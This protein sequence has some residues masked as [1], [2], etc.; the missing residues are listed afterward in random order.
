MKIETKLG[1]ST[2]V[3]ILA[4]FVSVFVAQLRVQQ[5]DALSATVTGERLPV[6]SLI[7]D[8]RLAPLMSVRALESYMLF[9]LDPDSSARFRKE[10]R[11]RLLAGENSYTKLLTF[12]P[13][14]SPE[15]LGRIRDFQAGVGQLRELEEEVERQ[16]ELHTPEGTSQAYDLIQKRI[17]PLDSSLFASL[18]GF[19]KTQEADRDHE[20]ELLGHAN[21]SVLV[22]LWFDSSVGALI[23]GIV[24]FLLG[25]RITRAIRLVVQRADAIAGGDLTGAPLAI[26]SKDQIGMLAISMQQMQESLAG[27][28]G[29]VVETAGELSASAVSMRSASDQVHHR[30]DQQTQQTQQTATAMQEMSASIA[31]VSRHTQSA[32]ESAR[33]AAQTAREGGAIVRQML[34]GMASIASAVSETSSTVGLL[35]ADS[36]RISQIVTVIDEIARKTN[37]LALNAAI[38]AARAGEQGRGFAVVAGEVRH[39]AESTAKAT[40]EIAAMIQGVQNRTE[41]AIGSMR[42]GNTTVEQGVATTNLAGESL[43]RIIGMAERV[44]RMITQIAIAASQQA[45]AADQSS[46]A[47]DSIHSLSNEN[48]GELAT[49]TSGIERLRRTAA[50]LESHVERFR[51]AGPSAGAGPR[52]SSPLPLTPLPIAALPLT[53]LPL[54]P[55]AASALHPA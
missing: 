3:L 22:A 44:E 31:E 5:A 29:T 12:G 28:I 39:L 15:D 36:R 14:L 42:A 21:R 50:S 11:D 4:M 24:S 20:M 49:T 8:I 35:G 45:A 38:E 46:A 26:D 16:N 47:L 40:S 18:N 23:G 32:V 2:G 6:I 43:E 27:I 33:S 30:V 10:R 37:L 41:S 55:P 19:V 17:L 25:R 54:A 7:R 51:L 9:G 34:D 48:L 1:L 53:P 52:Q 13:R